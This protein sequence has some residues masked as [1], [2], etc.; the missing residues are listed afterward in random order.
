MINV[1]FHLSSYDST[2][3]TSCSFILIYHPNALVSYPDVYDDLVSYPDVYD[4]LVSYLDV[5]VSYPITLVSY[6]ITLVSYPITLISYL[7]TTTTTTM[8][9]YTIIH[10]YLI[11]EPLK[12][13]F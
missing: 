5:L 10:Y 12:P 13:D 9:D 11:L 8:V 7:T 3:F 4:D 1:F 2:V 6:P